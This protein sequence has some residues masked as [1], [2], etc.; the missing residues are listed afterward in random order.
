MSDPLYRTKTWQR[1]REQVLARDNYLC[2]RCLGNTML[3][4]ADTVHHVR[5]LEQH[6]ELAL[7]PDNLMSLCCDCH[8]AIHK[9]GKHKELREPERKARIVTV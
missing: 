4:K 8:N 3:T 1:I 9:R 2:Q 5:E 6:P 7:E